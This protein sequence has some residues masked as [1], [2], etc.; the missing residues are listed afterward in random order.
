MRKPHLR[1]FTKLAIFTVYKG[2]GVLAETPGSNAFRDL[3]EKMP[4]RPEIFDLEEA[5]R[6]VTDGLDLIY[7]AVNGVHMQRVLLAKYSSPLRR[8]F[9]RSVFVRMFGVTTCL[10]TNRLRVF[11]FARSMWPH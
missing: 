3:C 1:W 9:P 7:A 5:Y 2:R 6:Y 10:Q 11:R 4:V 8:I